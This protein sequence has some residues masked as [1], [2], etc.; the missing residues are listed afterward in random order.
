[1]N[2]IN[3]GG[4]QGSDSFD[5]SSVS[6]SYIDNVNPSHMMNNRDLGL[7]SRKILLNENETV[8]EEEES[9]ATEGN[10]PINL[11]S[12]SAVGT[13]PNPSLVM[14]IVEDVVNEDQPHNV[15]SSRASRFL[16]SDNEWRQESLA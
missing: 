3:D 14:H 1:M 5:E 12:G 10:P 8:R 7:N 15:Q 4:D 11:L 6:S 2:I 16:S 9:V 13:E